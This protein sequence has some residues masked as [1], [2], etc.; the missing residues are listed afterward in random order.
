[1]STVKQLPT[2]AGEVREARTSQPEGGSGA[3]GVAGKRQRARQVLTLESIERRSLV[4][5]ECWEYQTD[6]KTEHNRRYVQV[7]HDGK[8][9]LVRRLAYELAKGVPT[10]PGLCVVPTC[11]NECCVN[12]KHQKAMRESEKCKRAAE[13]GAF[14]K[15]ARGR[16]IAEGSR[17]TK[18]KLTPEQAKEIR[19]SAESGPVLAAKYGI[20]K[21]LVNKI[22]RGE[23]WRDYSS[24][25]I[26]LGA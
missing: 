6:A 7:K 8:H 25:F 19:Y 15:I 2:P 21:S 14:S 17:K 5:G 1:M 16:A 4:C 18:A 10:K 9:I 22:K 3:A 11:G 23:A 20:N 26:W 24:P 13:Q 12:P